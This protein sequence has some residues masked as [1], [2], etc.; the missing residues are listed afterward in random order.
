MAVKKKVT[1]KKT[2]T[3]KPNK[4]TYIA[5]VL[6]RSGSMSSIHK[7]TVDGINQQFEAIRKAGNV[8]GDT[9][10]TVVQFDT[11]I[12]TVMDSAKPDQL[13]E[14]GM[15]DFQP[16][17]GTAMYDGIWTAIN[18]LKSKPATKDTAYL[19]CVIS[20]GQENAS[21]EVTQQILTD[22]IK[23]LQDQGNWTFTYLLAN[24]DIHAAQQTFGASINNIATYNSTATG[25]SVTYTAT[26]NSLGS[27]MMTRGV[28]SGPMM[29]ESYGA[30]TDDVKVTLSTTK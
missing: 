20:D 2:R 4:K 30:F 7:Q 25:A 28:T 21:R 24:V 8:A 14:W 10:I 19:I 13:T 1:P 18:T 6:D 9:E 5:I 12:D 29:N 22:E 27:Y 23:R 11:E 15:N 17:G 3:K 26:A 16:R